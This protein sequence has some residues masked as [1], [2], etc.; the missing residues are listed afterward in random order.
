MPNDRVMASSPVVNVERRCCDLCNSVRLLEGLSPICHGLAD[1][2]TVASDDQAATDAA[3][4]IL[5]AGGTAVDAAIAVASSKNNKE[6]KE[7]VTHTKGTCLRACA[8][9]SHSR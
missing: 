4:A 3:W 6:D 8:K 5:E 9:S 2:P 7:G 1:G